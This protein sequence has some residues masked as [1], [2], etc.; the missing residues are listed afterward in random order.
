MRRQTQ[1]TCAARRALMSS[2]TAVSFATFFVT[3]NTV[4]LAISMLSG[5]ELRRQESEMCWRRHTRASQLTAWARIHRQKHACPPHPFCCRILKFVGWNPSEKSSKNGAVD[6]GHPPMRLATR[7][8]PQARQARVH[9]SRNQHITQPARKRTV[10]RGANAQT[11]C[12]Q[13]G[14]IQRERSSRGHPKRYARPVR[15][16]LT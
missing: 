3:P 15:F 1:D 16:A 11:T 13:I 4:S 2:D 12:R 10:R 14:H 6:T 7:N 9:T 5:I 8:R